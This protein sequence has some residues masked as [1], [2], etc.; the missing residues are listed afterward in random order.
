MK[1]TRPLDKIDADINPLFALF[2]KHSG[3]FMMGLFDIL[4]VFIIVKIKSPGIASSKQKTVSFSSKHETN[5]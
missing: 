3:G 1:P 4:L 5:C 2:H